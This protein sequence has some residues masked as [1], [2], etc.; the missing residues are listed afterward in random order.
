MSLNSASPTRIHRKAA[1][2]FKIFHSFSEVNQADWV[3]A[4]APD[5]IFVTAD[6][7]SVMEKCS[8]AGLVFR[9]AIVYA[10]DAPVSALV[11]QLLNVGEKKLGGILN[12][13]DK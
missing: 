13:E 2:D 9:Y 12:F 6:Y 11:F 8:P 5:D 7:L 10:N 1:I 3:T 4:I